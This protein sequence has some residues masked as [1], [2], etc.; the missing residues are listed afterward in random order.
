[1]KYEIVR[2]PGLS[3]VR[4]SGRFNYA[5]HASY[6]TVLDLFPE[7]RCGRIVIDLSH[8][9]S[10]DSAG[11]GMLIISGV[12][13]ERHQVKLEVRNP[14]GLVRRLMELGRVDHHLGC[15]YV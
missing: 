8:L 14:R 2:S 6:R 15:V 1:M 12:E 7:Q 13:A 10:I 4:L 3:E 11:L 9:E 5:D